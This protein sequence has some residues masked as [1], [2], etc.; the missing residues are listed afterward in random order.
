MDLNDIMMPSSPAP[1]YQAQP[2]ITLEKMMNPTNFAEGL[3]TTTAPPEEALPLMEPSVIKNQGKEPELVS[4]NGKLPLFDDWCN[5][6]GMVHQYFEKC[7]RICSNADGNIGY[8]N[9][10]VY[11]AP[12]SWKETKRGFDIKYAWGKDNIE[13]KIKLCPEAELDKLW[14]TTAK[15]WRLN[16]DVNTSVFPIY[17]G[18]KDE[19]FNHT[20]AFSNPLDE[21]SKKKPKTREECNN[22]CTND[23]NCIGYNLY[24]SKQEGEYYC[25]P[26]QQGTRIISKSNEDEM[27]R[28]KYYGSHPSAIK[29]VFN[30]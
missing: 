22:E 16:G 11:D 17:K 27:N 3:Q 6:E 1:P 19:V 13:E 30:Y 18:M 20:L 10:S 26:A 5:K 15:P 21:F 24:P 7:G 14:D 2:E 4:I 29:K 25:F 8:Y 12:E 23:R 9:A 28:L